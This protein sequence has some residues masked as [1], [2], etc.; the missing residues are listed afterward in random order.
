MAQKNRGPLVREAFQISLTSGKLQTVEANINGARRYLV[1]LPQNDQ[2]ARVATCLDT[3]WLQCA[4]VFTAGRDVGLGQ[5]TPA[6]VGAA[7]TNAENATLAITEAIQTLGRMRTGNETTVAAMERHLL[8]AGRMI[9]L[10]FEDGRAE[11]N[12]I[13]NGTTHVLPVNKHKT[14]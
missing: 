5:S 6:A 4:L 12:D 2:A 14:V 8:D 7:A 1:A 3:C 10:L 11:G 13:K 9:A